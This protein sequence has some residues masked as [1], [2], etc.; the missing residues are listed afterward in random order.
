MPGGNPA[1]PMVASCS[2]T[3]TS[4]SVSQ[5]TPSSRL[6]YTNTPFDCWN[7]L[8]GI[9]YAFSWLSIE[10]TA[11]ARRPELSYSSVGLSISSVRGPIAGLV[12]L[13]C[14]QVNP[15]S[16]ELTMP[17]RTLELNVG[18]LAESDESSKAPTR[19]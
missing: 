10:P 3:D 15:P 19:K 6:R 16:S 5:V 18:G 12:K 14:V 7:L 4:G 1:S 13:R 17:T 9:W 11:N 8:P 2:V